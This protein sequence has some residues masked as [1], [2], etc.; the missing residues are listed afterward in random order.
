MH[1]KKAFSATFILG[2]IMFGVSQIYALN[3]NITVTQPIVG[4]EVV[5]QRIAPQFKGEPE[6]ARVS[7]KL[8]ITNRESSTI[9]VDRILIDNHR[10]S[11]FPTPLEIS[12]GKSKYFQNC[13]CFREIGGV[14]TRIAYSHVIKAPSPS[15]PLPQSVRV[16]VYF[17]GQ[18]D[19]EEITVMLTAGVNVDGSLAYPGKK[20]DLFDNHV[21]GASSN[22]ASGHQVFGLDMGVLKW[23][24]NQW[25]RHYP[26]ADINENTANYSYGKPIYAMAGGTVCWAL[27]DHTERV[28][29]SAN[30]RETTASASLGGR[31]N[32]GGNQIYIKSGNEIALYA[33]FQKGSIPT[34]LLTTG[35]TVKR[36]QYIGKVGMS[37]DTG[38]P[39]VH[40]HVK[41]VHKKGAPKAGK[42]MNNC[43]AGPFRPMAFK[44][45]FSINKQQ[46]TYLALGN[47]L[48]SLSWY[49]MTNHSAQHDYSL[50]YPSRIAFR[51]CISCIDNR[52]YVGVWQKA[53][54]IELRV[55]SNSYGAFIQ[56]S[57]DLS[58]DNFRLVDI[59]IVRE[60]N[61][62]YYVGIYKRGG[63]KYDF[64]RIRGWS[65]FVAKNSERARKGFR[66][67]DMTSY[68]YG[69]SRMYL[70]VYRSGRYG[71]G[72]LSYSNWSDFYERRNKLANRGYKLVDIEAH[73]SNGVETYIGVFRK[74]RIKQNLVRKTSWASFIAARRSQRRKGMR[75]VDV[76]VFKTA[77]RTVFV[78]V[79][80]QGGGKDAFYSVKS[81]AKFNQLAEK[82]RA[83]GWRL[84][85]MSIEQ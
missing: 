60:N 7:L 24:G 55:K 21:W 62:R 58:K 46:A 22:H 36:G 76:A 78:G 27:N 8:K 32:A 10:V 40:I 14:K 77:S 33:H 2:Y 20:G 43:D 50:L 45:M 71:H 67:I 6:E 31:Y 47:V 69:S 80:N 4:G 17:V 83:K 9:A 28:N 42:K 70:G 59:N 74:S 63:G 16:R 66:L 29:I 1:K 13:N 41:G 26:G 52:Q 11:Q 35:A 82:V 54:H 5:Y 15:E 85:D 56:K 61:K 72:L 49:A 12:P 19:P 81:Y 68:K 51:L 38:G 30:A 3:V 79:F 53:S 39:H 44:N 64:I 18:S 75:L 48:S 84:I 34:E 37:G 57:R 65:N 25:L 23:V 73:M